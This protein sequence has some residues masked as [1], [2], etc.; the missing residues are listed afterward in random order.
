[1]LSSTTK[2]ILSRLHTYCSHPPIHG[3]P[4]PPCASCS[5]SSINK[6]T[7]WSTTPYARRAAVLVILFETLD[8]K[9]RQVELSAVLTTRSANLSSYSGHVALPG[10]KS[11]FE[12][13]SACMTAHREAHEEINFPLTENPVLFEQTGKVFPNNPKHSAQTAVSNNNNDNPYLITDV[14]NFPAYL[15]RNLLAV[16]PVIAYVPSLCS[17]VPKLST[18]GTIPESY[19]GLPHVLGTNQELA[20]VLSQNGEVAEVFS[21]PLRHFLYKEQPGQGI[22]GSPVARGSSKDSARPWYTGNKA[23]W[24]GLEWYSHNYS[25]LRRT[26]KKVGEPSHFRVWGLTA[27][28][29]V[30]VARIAYGQEPEMEYSPQPGDEELILAM[31]EKGVMQKERSKADLAFSF[32]D[33]FGKDSPLLKSRL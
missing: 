24:N 8:P 29:M 23:K 32:E 5:S 12:E 25:V 6:F 17:G 21:V 30:D 19:Y 20:A 26:G 14:G 10:G 27:R 4:S 22:P 11:D 7:A 18:P 9:T 1:M 3:G 13:E 16:T 2:A 15:A 33:T 31:N 28:I